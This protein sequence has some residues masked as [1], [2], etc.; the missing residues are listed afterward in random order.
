MLYTNKNRQKLTCTNNRLTI[1]A[2]KIKNAAMRTRINLSKMFKGF[3][4]LLYR[5]PKIT[6]LNFRKWRTR[7]MCNKKLSKKWKRYRIYSNRNKFQMKNPSQKKSRPLKRSV[8]NNLCIATKWTIYPSKITQI[9]MSQPASM[10]FKCISTSWISYLRT[11]IFP[12]MKVSLINLNPT[13]WACQYWQWILS[14]E[15]LV[16]LVLK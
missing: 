5:L 6:T 8:I 13:I 14:F 1:K 10:I 16:S 15:N 3:K 9:S 4:L 7:P 11:I 12:R 2:S